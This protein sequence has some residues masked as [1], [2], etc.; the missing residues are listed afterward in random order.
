[1][2]FN[3]H[4]LITKFRVIEKNDKYVVVKLRIENHDFRDMEHQVQKLTL[5]LKTKNINRFKKG[6]HVPH[7]DYKYLKNTCV[8]K[9]TK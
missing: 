6:K 2:D 5:K 4:Q 3:R 8:M 9:R 1:M 7:H